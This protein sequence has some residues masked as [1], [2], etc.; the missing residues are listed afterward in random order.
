V[1]TKW[2][3]ILPEA[4]QALS[5]L[6]QEKIVHL[7]IL[8]ERRRLSAAYASRTWQIDR[9]TFLAEL[10]SAI[11]EMR[12]YFEQHGLTSLGDLVVE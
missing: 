6:R 4:I 11:R 1:I 10:D 2:N 3:Q 5:P 7:M 8:P 9:P 12:M